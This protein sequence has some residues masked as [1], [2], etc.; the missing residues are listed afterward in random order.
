[1]SQMTLLKTGLRYLIRRPLISLLCIV[2]VALGVAVVIA[3]DLANESASRAFNLSTETVAGRATHQIVGASGSIDE[4]LFRKVRVDLGIRESAP[5]V[6]AFAVALELDQQ[7][8]RVLG[9]DVFSEAPFRSYLG[10]GNRAFTNNDLTA[11]FTEPDAMLVGESLATRYN[12]TTNSPV[13]FRVGD[14]R[15]TMR[16]VGV[17]RSEDDQSRRA[18]DG[19]AI[20]DVA[21]AQQLFQMTGRLSHIDL[22][23]DERTPEGRAR[24]DAVRTVLTPDTSIVKPQQRSQ[25]VE[26]LGDAFRLNL[27]AL[28]LL[29][30]VVGMF[31]IYNTITFSVVQ[32]R[33]V[34]GTLRCLGVTRREIF[35]A[36]LAETLVL[37][38]IGG[39]I[40][41]GLG[42]LLGRGAVTLVTQTIND[43]YYVVN[44]RDVSVSPWT[45]LKGFA[46]G[47]GASGLAA[48]APAYEATSI[49]PITALKRTAIEQRVQKLLPWLAL[50]GVLLLVIG[51]GLLLLTSVLTVNLAGI[52]FVLIGVALTTPLL[53]VWLM[54]IAVP[55]LD[56]LSG[57]TGRMSARNV[58]NAISRTAIAIASL[59]VAVSVIIGLQSMIGSFRKTVV[60]WLNT[61][62]TA[63]IYVA[64]V[65][66]AGTANTARMDQALV[67]QFRA[68]DGVEDVTLFRRATVEFRPVSS[69]DADFRAV[70][71]LSIGSSRERQNDTFVW[72]ARAPDGLWASMRGQDE[73]QVSEPFANR[74]GITRQN[75]QIILRTATGARTLTVV[76]VYYDYASDAGVIL[77]RR[78]AYAQWY[79][80]DTISSIAVYLRDGLSAADTAAAFRTQFAGRELLISANRELRDNALVV[81]DRTFAITSA[82]NLLATVVAFIGVLSALMALQIE[83]TRELGMLR[84]NGMTTRQLWGMTLTETG[85]M[86][87]VAGLLSIPTGILLAIVL[88]YII[89]LRSFGWTIQLSLDSSTFVQAMAVALLSALLAAIYPMLRLSRIQIAR[90]VRLE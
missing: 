63:D 15:I 18:L 23:A 14:R 33:P 58:T 34:I 1:M 6:E 60:S 21:T 26:S 74:H 16:V 46:L 28:S 13:T 9:V 88:V 25:S 40:G 87:A 80:D 57:I 72:T 78:D 22:I 73:V 29:A 43:L 52:F 69:T 27:T 41:L 51:A 39:V 65:T 56:R 62:L 59:M 17:I 36:I 8:V 49:A 12:L 53:T 11:F 81:F 54:R 37:G 83:R 76:A 5:V 42:V 32:R 3:I 77:T 75:N 55:V 82:L 61:S 85:L 89:N 45:L 7:P 86:G 84:A 79:A 66:T 35:G 50:V 24:L 64:P 90:A 19:L 71:M 10:E 2:G 70:T 68:T 67:D 31:L 30:L 47:L 38:A 20:V 44:V 4:D 48:L